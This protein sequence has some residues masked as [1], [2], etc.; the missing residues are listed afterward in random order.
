MTEEGLEEEIKPRALTKTQ[1]TRG[2]GQ[3]DFLSRSSAEERFLSPLNGSGKSA[4][5]HALYEK[6]LACY[7][8]WMDG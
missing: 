2:E 8:G 4:I 1:A 7:F 6:C 3:C 5:I